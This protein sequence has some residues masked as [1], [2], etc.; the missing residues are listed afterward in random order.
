MGMLIDIDQ[1]DATPLY[2]QLRRQI[3]AAVANGALAPGDR[4]PSVR[5]LAVDLGINLHT[6]N[7]AYATL[8]DDGYIIMRRGSGA[9]VAE[10]GEAVNRTGR[11]EESLHRLVL[12]HKAGGG[13]MASFLIMA[14][15]Q[16][17]RI[18]GRG[19]QGPAQGGNNE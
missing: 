12:A 15:R 16:C 3:I 17:E 8:R 11:T 9:V 4:L 10:H 18:Y 19:L 6:V 14:R 1:G 2:E 5:S 13:D 7:R